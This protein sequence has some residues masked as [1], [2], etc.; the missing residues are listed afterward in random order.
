MVHPTATCCKTTEG[1]SCICAAQAKCSCG[2]NSALQCSC[3][4]SSDENSTS[5]P[6]CSCRKWRPAP[7]IV[8][9]ANLWIGARP[10]GQCT[11]D[12][13]ETENK[14][15]DGEKCACGK[16]PQ[17][18]C[19]CEKAEGVES[20]IEIDFTTPIAWM[21]RS[22]HV[23]P[24]LFGEFVELHS[25][26]FGDPG[27]WRLG[28]GHT[29]SLTLTLELLDRIITSWDMKWDIDSIQ[30]EFVDRIFCT[31]TSNIKDDACSSYVHYPSWISIVLDK[32]AER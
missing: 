15:V 13:S 1:G 5:G 32:M 24:T 16:R 22:D 10:V 28:L 8:T 7:A 26:P 19:T 25:H 4:K 12:R 20:D 11:C 6:R 31:V 14:V 2:E 30:I 27:W 9:S 29:Y 3:E 18:S 21:I 23:S 17:A